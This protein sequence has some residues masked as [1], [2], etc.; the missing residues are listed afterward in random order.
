MFDWNSIALAVLPKPLGS[1]WRVEKHLV[2]HPLDAGL[3]MSIGLPA[4]QI[5][6]YRLRLPDCRGLHVQDFSTHYL[7]HIDRTDPGCDLVQHLVSDTPGT[8]LASAALVGGLLGALL[9]RSD[10]SMLAGALLG[11]AIGGIA[12]AD[13]QSKRR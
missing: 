13:D 7:V 12:I 1:K 10:K 11:A 4:G 8:Y 6:D 9:G 5:A 3:R 2:P